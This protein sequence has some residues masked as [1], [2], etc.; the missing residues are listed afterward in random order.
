[1][2]IYYF[3]LIV[4]I[5]YILRTLSF[6]I[7][8]KIEDKKNIN[9]IEDKYTPFVSIVVPSRNEEQNIANCLNSLS[10]SDYPLDKFEIIA[11]DD[12]STDETFLILSTLLDSIPNLKIVKLE[13]ESQKGNLK[14]KPGAS[15]A[16]I[17]Q[18]K[19]EIIL[20]TDADCILPKSWLRRMVNEY[21]NPKTLMVASFTTVTIKSVFDVIQA[22]D[23]LYSCTLARGG[24]GL[25]KIVG[26]FGNNLSIKKDIFDNL[27]GYRKIPFTITEDFALMNAVDNFIPLENNNLENNLSNN[28]KNHE[29]IRYI[30]D[31]KAVIETQPCKTFTEYIK[32]KKRWAIGGKALGWKAFLLVV[33]SLSLWFGILLSF[34]LLKFHLTAILIITRLVCDIWVIYPILKRVKYIFLSSW[35]IPSI[36]YFMIIELII[37][38]TLFS[39]KIEWKN[40][41]FK[42]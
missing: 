39:N 21:R 7:G 24:V 6:K 40:Q 1:M 17:D 34:V 16:G 28:T 31:P 2:S 9:N 5:I 37:P 14:G 33:S 36:L 27:G 30:C 10:K 8:N 11:I 19:G 18:A 35:L 4:S 29:N 3:I 12:R 23:W 15:Q 13:N 20:M 25:G 42:Q 26:C 22:I 38:F 32:Q 41:V